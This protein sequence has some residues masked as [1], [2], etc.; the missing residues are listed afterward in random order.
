[1]GKSGKIKCPRE[2]AAA[3]PAVVEVTPKA[4]SAW[5]ARR[6]PP[7]PVSPQQAAN[8]FAELAQQVGRAF[9]L[10]VYGAAQPGEARVNVRGE[11]SPLSRYNAEQEA[12]E[13]GRL[14]WALVLA[15]ADWALVQGL[16]C[17]CTC[18]E[19]RNPAPALSVG[20]SRP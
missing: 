6:L 5:V 17:T 14:T 13:V 12:C 16:S 20:F 15:F 18:H 10:P 11:S 3:G 7:G 19:V 4:V 2:N 9:G 8:L 1:M